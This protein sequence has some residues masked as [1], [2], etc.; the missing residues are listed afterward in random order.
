MTSPSSSSCD[1]VA[2]FGNASWNGLLSISKKDIWRQSIDR[3]TTACSCI[4]NQKYG[5][6]CIASSVKAPTVLPHMSRY[7]KS[8]QEQ[9]YYIDLVVEAV[10]SY[11]NS[12]SNLK[13]SVTLLLPD[14]NPELDIYDRRFL[15]RLVWGLATLCVLEKQQRVR[16]VVQGPSESG[17]LPLAVAGLFRYLNEDYQISRESWNGKLQTHVSI[18]TLEECLTQNVNQDYFIVITPTNAVSTPITEQLIQLTQ[19]YNNSPIL[20]INPSLKD[21]PSTDGVMQVRGRKERME[22]LETFEDV[23]YLRPLYKTG[24]LYPIQ[25]L[26]LRK[27]PL[28]WQ[29]WKMDYDELQQEHYLLLEECPHKPDRSMLTTLFKS[30]IP[31]ST[32]I[33][34]KNTTEEA[35]PVLLFLSFALLLLFFLILRNHM[36]KTFLLSFWPPALKFRCK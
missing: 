26:L 7:P 20:L 24:T 11:D 19:K 21:V 3:R 5:P 27:Y 13:K 10:Q 25:G 1:C 9:Q 34:N 2:F 33:S 23:F 29:V 6:L 12:C 31:H 35:R 28:P 14:L 4:R 17:G 22:F 36:T 8:L 32:T 30:S 18:S 16:L 15:L